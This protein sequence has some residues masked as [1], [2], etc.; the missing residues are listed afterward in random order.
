MAVPFNRLQSEVLDA[1]GSKEAYDNLARF[2]GVIWWLGQK[3]NIEYVTGG[4][5]NFRERIMYG[6]NTNIDFR[7]K[8]TSIPQTDDDGF[9][10]SSVPQVLID[11]AIKY[12]QQELDQVRGNWALARDLV[13]DK[14]AQFHDTWCITIA[15]KLRQPAPTAGLDPLTLLPNSSNTAN[16]ILAPIAPASQT[17]T[18]A[19]IPRSEVVTLPG[20]GAV[21]VRWWAN[22]YSNTSYDLTTAAGRRG[23][24]LDVYSKCIRGNGQGWEPDFGLISDVVDASLSSG[25]DQLRR[26][27]AD[28]TVLKLGFDNIRFK[29]AVLFIDRGAELQNGSAGKVAFLNSKALKLKVLEGSGGVTKEM[30]DEKNNLKAL[31]IFWKHKNMSEFNTLNYNW[32]GYCTM[33]LVP[34]SLQD[35]GLADNCT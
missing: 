17:A 19:G 31:P 11:G 20:S 35:L 18:T 3:G 34:K 2:D 7:G 1:Y 33:N 23:L 16:G 27:T 6:L 12:N 24:Q 14:T 25:A 22:Q 10:M 32:V 21:Q 8:N 29:K 9:T 4:G 26:Y 13:T 5:P 28:E 30:L 15:N